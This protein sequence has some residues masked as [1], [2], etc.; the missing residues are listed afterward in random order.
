MT[1]SVGVSEVSDKN[2]T[3]I[4]ESEVPR[5]MVSRMKNIDTVRIASDA[6]LEGI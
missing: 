2:E 1:R 3:R 4:E 5:L 6:Y